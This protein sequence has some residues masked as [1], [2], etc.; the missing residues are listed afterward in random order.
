MQITLFTAK[1]TG[2][3]ANCSY[4]V[5]AVVSSAEELQKAVRADHVCASYKNN[6]RGIDNFLS[7]DCLVMDIDNDHSENPEEWITSERIASLF[8]DVDYALATS[9]SH[10]IS[11]GGKAVRPKFVKRKTNKGMVVY[12]LSLKEGQDFLS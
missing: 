12:G 9:R 10:M 7:S 4:P 1:C 5:K 3:K 6:Y 11:K 2:N 8:E